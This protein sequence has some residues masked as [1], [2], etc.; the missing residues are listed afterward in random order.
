MVT[1]LVRVRAGRVRGYIGVHFLFPIE[2]K[3]RKF[4]GRWL[5][6][7]HWIER[8][9]KMQI[10]P[11]NKYPRHFSCNRLKN[12]RRCYYVVTRYPCSMS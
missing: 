1:W 4:K 12:T 7:I 2:I 5:V 6:I 10:F 9:V 11:H 3:R 8:R